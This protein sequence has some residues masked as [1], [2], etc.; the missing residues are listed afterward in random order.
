[1]TSSVEISFQEF[2]SADKTPSSFRDLLVLCLTRKRTLSFR[3]TPSAVILKVEEDGLAGL[4]IHGAWTA[5]SFR[6]APMGNNGVKIIAP[7]LF[8]TCEGRLVWDQ[9]YTLGHSYRSIA[10][11]FARNIYLA[12]CRDAP[13]SFK[14]DTSAAS[15]QHLRTFRR[16]YFFVLKAEITEGYFQSQTADDVLNF[17][18]L[19]AFLPVVVFENPLLE[20]GGR[21]LR[22]FV[23]VESRNDLPL[24]KAQLMNA[25]AAV[26]SNYKS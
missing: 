2:F 21:L 23:G 25:R 4:K 1:M 20:S 14:E 16:H 22:K 10:D 24:L 26:M 19:N 7:L 15:A 3:I 9:L 13:I 8:N 11:F 5:S 17:I 6:S 18:F 12:A